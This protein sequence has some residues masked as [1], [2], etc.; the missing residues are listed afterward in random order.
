MSFAARTTLSPSASPPHR[1]P[2]VIKMRTTPGFSNK[3]GYWGVAGGGGP[4][5]WAYN[6]LG[7]GAGAGT[8]R[9]SK[10]ELTYWAMM[11]LEFHLLSDDSDLSPQMFDLM[12]QM[13]NLMLQMIDWMLQMSALWQGER[14]NWLFFGRFYPLPWCFALLQPRHSS[15]G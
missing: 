7:A 8:G 2:P 11:V 4:A 10:C 9:V 1:V 5:G 6:A 12:L 14:W 13:L 15:K 3:P